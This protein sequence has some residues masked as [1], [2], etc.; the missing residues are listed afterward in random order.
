MPKINLSVPHQLGREEAKTRIAR[1]IADSRSRFAGQVT[2]VSE[3]WTG[4][5]DSFRFR[6]KGFGVNGSLDVQADQVSIEIHLPLAAYPWKGRIESD[7]LNHARE[8]LA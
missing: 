4:Y 5:V 6:A 7:I 8:L 1:L 2:D 3:S